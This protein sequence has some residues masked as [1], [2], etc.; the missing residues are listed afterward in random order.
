MSGIRKHRLARLTIAIGLGMG[1]GASRSAGPEIAAPARIPGPPAEFA[2]SASCRTCHEEFYEKWATSYHGLA[3]RPCT[4]EFARSHLEP[5]TSEIEVEGTRYRV[6]VKGPRVEMHAQDSEG[7]TVY[8]VEYVLG[9]KY[10]YYFLTPGPSGRWQVLPLAFDV[11]T[12]EWY[13]MAGSITRHVGGQVHRA[14]P[15]TSREFT[16]NTSCYGC[17]VSQLA[18]NYSPATDTYDTVWTEPGINCDT[19]HGPGGE[20]SRLMTEAGGKIPADLK[21]IRNG[22]FTTTQTNSLCAPCHAK[23]VPISTGFKPGESFF[24]HYNLRTYEDPDFFPDG[25]ELGEDFT[26]TTWRLC[27]CLASGELD[28]LHCHT[29]SGRNRHVGADADRAC[30][31][32]HANYVTDPASHS[33]HPAES[34]ASRCVACHMPR[35]TFARMDRHDHSLLAPTPA[36]TLAFGSPNACNLCH[37]DHDARWADEWVRKWYPRNYQAPILRRARLVAAARAGDWTR[38]AEMLAYITSAERNE[39]FA[40]SLIRLLDSCPRS[41]KWPALVAALRDPSPLVRSAAAFSLRT[42]PD[43]RV[44]DSLIA[45]TAD[46]FRVVRVNAACALTYHPGRVADPR[47]RAQIDRAGAEYEESLRCVPDDPAGHYNLGI[48]Y[49]RRG[50]LA[51]AVDAYDIALSL[52]PANIPALVNLSMAYAG[53]S[54]PARAEGALRR[55]LRLDPTHAAANYNLGLLLVDLGR[56]AQAEHCFRTTLKTDPTFAPAAHSLAL[57]LPE[58]QLNEAIA[59]CRK[60][61]ELRP[62]QTRYSYTLAR[63]LHRRGDLPAAVAVLRGLLQRHPNHSDARSLLA[64][65]RHEQEHDADHPVGESRSPN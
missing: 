33:H 34:E 46:P 64:V 36:T 31:P 57:L 15:W 1:G 6:D 35:T 42:C 43:P 47:V 54:Q 62:D 48:Y 58:D 32:C 56:G 37:H 30:L 27:P 61:A 25:R 44:R 49:H 52:E 18:K 26:Y 16:F 14:P 4:L 10:V 20:H 2:D 8:P 53:L 55:A 5:Q 65:V 19:C 12:R 38:L 50:D 60:A 29:S 22:N 45:T 9:G 23:M 59:L 7:V 13:D 39:I 11:R 21:I 63:L 41:E 3:M 28:C 51:R 24:D 17:H 40:T